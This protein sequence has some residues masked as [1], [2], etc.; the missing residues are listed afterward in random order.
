MS[1]ALVLGGG[2]VTGIAWMTGLLHA[3]EQCGVD[4]TTADRLIGTSAG[5]VVAAQLGAGRPLSKLYDQQTQPAAKEIGAKFKAPDLLRFAGLMARAH[6]A[7]NRLARLGTAA[8]QMHPE[9]ST[10]RQEVIRGRLGDMDWPT[11]RDLQITAVDIE[12]GELM[13]WTKDSGCDVVEAVA[14]SCAVPVVWPPVEINGR[15]YM[16]GGVRSTT[17]AYLA[18]GCDTVV[19]IA[20]IPASTKFSASKIPSEVLMSGARR[21]AMVSPDAQSRAAIGK[22]VLDPGKRVASA[23][24]GY[25][26]GL[27]QA[28][29]MAA[30]WNA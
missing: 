21:W 20:P 28:E 30:G 9:L 7:P 6:Q 12:T 3:F 22:N 10:A 25:A 15:F 19:V 29:E 4:L 24:A 5:S 17:N 16:D 27:R 14:S 23:L 13:V 2:G 11:D 8:K 26:Q 1:T 18:E